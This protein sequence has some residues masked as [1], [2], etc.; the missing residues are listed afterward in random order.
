MSTLDEVTSALLREY[1]SRKVCV[2]VRVCCIRCLVQG[3]R[4]T[5]KE[6]ERECPRTETSLSKRSEIVKALKAETLVRRNKER[7]NP[8]DTMMEMLVAYIGDKTGARM[9]RKDSQVCYSRS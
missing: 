7:S 4:S 3:F 9:T 1:L 5:L 6:F 8:L 2:S